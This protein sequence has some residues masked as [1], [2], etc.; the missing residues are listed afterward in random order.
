MLVCRKH[1]LLYVIFRNLAMCR[2]LSLGVGLGGGL[3]FVFVCVCVCGGNWLMTTNISFAQDSVGQL[4]G[5][6][7]AV[8][9]ILSGITHT[10]AVSWQVGWGLS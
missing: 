8:L 5:W 3:C 1:Q 10:T 4:L 9:L 2:F 6:S 7:Q